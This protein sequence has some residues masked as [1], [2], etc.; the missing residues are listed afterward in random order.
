MADFQATPPSPHNAPQRT[1]ERV[2]ADLKDRPLAAAQRLHELSLHAE[3]DNHFKDALAFTDAHLQVAKESNATQSV[4][5]ALLT[6]GKLLFKTSQFSEAITDL[7]N[8][9]QTSARDPSIPPPHR[10]HILYTA[11]NLIAASLWRQGDRVAAATALSQ[12][13]RLARER[14]GSGSG[15]VVKALFEQAHLA[16]EMRAPESEILDRIDECLREPG[17]NRDR[18]SRLSE[19]AQALYQN[20][21]W[22]AATHTLQVVSELSEERGERTQALLALANIACRR[23]DTRGVHR[24]VD[25]AESLLMDVAPLPPVERHI[26]HLRAMA[27]LQEGREESYR[28]HIYKAQ[29]RADSEELK[30]EDRIYIQFVRAQVLRRSGLHEQARHEIEEAQQIVRRAIVS[31]ITQCSMLLQQGFCEQVEGNY[32]ESNTL[33]DEA[34]MIVRDDLDRNA[35]LEARGRCLKAHNLYSLFT[36]GDTSGKAPTTI[37]REAKKNAEIALRLLSEEELD[38]YHQKTLL[39]LLCAIANHLGLDGELASYERLLTT[40]EARYPD[41]DL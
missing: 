7:Q 16:I 4:V 3:K 40:L 17:T 14:F 35:I 8:A 25:Q 36:Y 9:L 2:L 18:A 37:I 34:L 23:A 27:A 26:A 41:N 22:D 12:T 28:E 13:V 33:I 1:I 39:R 29:Q 10:L 5:L 6:R 15:E 38:P 19:L 30:I 32:H 31:P 24:Y 11:S 21:R 20:C